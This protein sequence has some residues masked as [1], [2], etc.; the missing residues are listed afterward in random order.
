LITSTVKLF[1]LKSMY[2]SSRYHT[3]H[4]QVPS[5]GVNGW[6][7]TSIPSC[8][9]MICRGTT[10]QTVSNL[11]Y[12]NTRRS[13]LFYREITLRS[14]SEKTVNPERVSWPSTLTG[15]RDLDWANDSKGHIYVEASGEDTG[16]VSQ[17][18]TSL[19]TKLCSF[20]ECCLV[21]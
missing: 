4:P 6:S 8:A 19:C 7:C 5:P 15:Q 1:S 11:S 20:Q 17:Y 18:T 10:F 2:M 12:M 21:G 9:F 14:S 13:M 16:E 3:M